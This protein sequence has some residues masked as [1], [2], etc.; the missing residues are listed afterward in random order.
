MITGC[1]PNLIHWLSAF[2]TKPDRR[3]GDGRRSTP[4]QFA[5]RRLLPR[6]QIGS[7]L[8]PCRTSHRLRGF[9]PLSV[10]VRGF[11][12]LP[13][14]ETNVNKTHFLSLSGLSQEQ[15]GTKETEACCVTPTIR[16]RTTTR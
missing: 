8:T 14:G 7:P 5:S 10:I 11:Q 15:I 4:I 2:A 16:M 1:D 3:L 12:H 9:R 13:S 6:G